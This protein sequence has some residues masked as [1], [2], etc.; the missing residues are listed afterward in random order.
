MQKI[1][2][3]TSKGQITLPIAWRRRIGARHIILE[4][5]GDRIEILPARLSQ[6]ESG[7]YTVLDALRDNTGGG[8]GEKRIHPL[9]QAIDSRRSHKEVPWGNQRGK[10]VW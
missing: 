4:T 5:K 2:T 6:K 8:I 9:V 10:E 1:Q 3:I 7:E